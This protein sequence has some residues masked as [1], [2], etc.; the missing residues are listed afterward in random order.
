MSA[1]DFASPAP[2]TPPDDTLL[3]LAATRSVRSGLLAAQ[4]EKIT[5]QGDCGA[6]PADAHA[7]GLWVLTSTLGT[8]TP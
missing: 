4:L 1:E 3:Q 5:L 2:L 6:W 8:R 7:G